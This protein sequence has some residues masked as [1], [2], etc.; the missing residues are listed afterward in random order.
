MTEMNDQWYRAALAE[1]TEAFAGLIGRAD[2]AT[3][4]P[5]C[6]EWTLGELAAHVGRA[7][8]WAAATVAT[9]AQ[10]MLPFEQ[11]EGLD[12]PEQAPKAADWLR[13]GA[14]RLLDA[15]R[16]IEPDAAVWNWMQPGPALFWVRRMVNETAVHRADAAIATGTTYDLPAERGVEVLDEGLHL[17]SFAATRALAPKYVSLRGTGQTLHVCATDPDVAGRGEWLVHREPGMVRVERGHADADVTLRGPLADLVLVMYR[18]VELDHPGV[19]II[20]DRAQMEHW[21]EHSAM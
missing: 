12:M 14:T 11:V 21:R 6:P 8:R 13:E 3:P 1:E 2:L 5:T 20:G 16:D 15:Q 19:E 17:V 9:R 4:V 7:H 18:R 10:L